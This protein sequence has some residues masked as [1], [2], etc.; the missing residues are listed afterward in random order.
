M[1]GKELHDWLRFIMCDNWQNVIY[2]A[3][4]TNSNA[5]QNGFILDGPV[6]IRGTFLDLFF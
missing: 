2:V 4:A 3:Y 5:L 1:A 6:L